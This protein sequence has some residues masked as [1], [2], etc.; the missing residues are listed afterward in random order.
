MSDRWMR[1]GMV[2]I[3]TQPLD[4]IAAH[5]A[6]E[7]PISLQKAR[8]G[9]QRAFPCPVSNGT[10]LSYLSERWQGLHAFGSSIKVPDA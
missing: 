1:V 9:F 10:K 4:V 7:M 2:G 8:K 5:E 3:L 6:I